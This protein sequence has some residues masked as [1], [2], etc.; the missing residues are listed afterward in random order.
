MATVRTVILIAD[1]IR[2]L[3]ILLVGK[4]R[5]KEFTDAVNRKWCNKEW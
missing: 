3:A 1:T 5:Q 4:Y 2:N